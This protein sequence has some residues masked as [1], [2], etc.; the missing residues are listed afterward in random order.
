MP[1]ATSWSYYLSVKS[2]DLARQQSNLQRQR[3]DYGNNDSSNNKIVWNNKNN[4]DDDDNAQRSSHITAPSYLLSRELH[5][6]IEK[7]SSL[8]VGDLALW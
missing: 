2:T 5:L 3:R 4:D 1:G 6:F 8:L 7:S